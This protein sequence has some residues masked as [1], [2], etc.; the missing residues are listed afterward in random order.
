MTVSNPRGAA[1]VRTALCSRI[2]AAAFADNLHL[3]LLSPCIGVVS[4]RPQSTGRSARRGTKDLVRAGVIPGFMCQ[5]GDFT[6]GNGTGGES[7]YGEKFA[8]ENFEKKH[9]GAPPELLPHSEGT[10]E[11]DRVTTVAPYFVRD[12]QSG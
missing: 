8:D 7:I 3:S 1:Y 9:A 5:G 6:R 4:A 2:T 10:R 12:Q 11:P